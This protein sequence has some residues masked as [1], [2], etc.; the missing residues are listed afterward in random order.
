MSDLR[1]YCERIAEDVTKMVNDPSAW[2]AENDMDED[3][4]YHISAWLDSV[5][6][7]EMSIGI[8][9]TY[10]GAKI[11]VAYGGPNIYVNTRT[12]TVDG[13]WGDEQASVEIPSEV[14]EALDEYIS[15]IRCDM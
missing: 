8:N 11:M 5:L 13:Y 2:L 9:G 12:G 1:S 15:E 7:V 6:D 14:C 3:Y 10:R 4:C